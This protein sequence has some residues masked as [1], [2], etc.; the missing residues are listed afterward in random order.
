MN[1][2]SWITM[3]VL[4]VIALV[5]V[6]WIIQRYVEQNRILK[7][8]VCVVGRIIEHRKQVDWGRQSNEAYVTI[9]YEYQGKTYTQEQQVS[10]NVYLTYPDQTKVNVY[11]LPDDPTQIVMKIV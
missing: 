2:E 6:N 8:G 4:G 10:R 11:F 1:L 7:N 3:L 5:I 9:S